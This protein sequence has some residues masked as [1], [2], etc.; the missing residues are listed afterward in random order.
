MLRELCSLAIGAGI[1]SAV[2]PQAYGQAA[3]INGE[4][5][6]VVT[7]S[8]RAAVG[9]AAVQIVNAATGFIEATRTE[10][11]GLYRFTLL[12]IGEYEITVKASGFADSRVTG[13][14]VNAGAAVTVNLMLQVAGTA[15]Q[16]DVDAEAQMTEPS[17]TAFSSILDHSA[18]S[19]LPLVSRNPYNFILFQPNVSGQANTEF[20][21][22][23]KVNANGFNGRINYELDGSNNTE[24][25]RSGVRLIPIS[26]SYVQEVQQVSNGFAP[27][28]GNTVGTVFNTI[29]RSGTN[30][31]HG[32]AMYIFRR[33]P[34]SARPKL[35]PAAAPT[36][37]INVDSYVA[38]AGG[39]IVRDKLFFFGSFEHVNRDLPAPVTVPTSII[40]QLRLPAS[41]ADSIP[42]RQ[43]VYFYMARADWMINPSNRL[44]LRYNHHANDSPYDY[45]SPP[46]GQ[47]LVSRT[48]NFVDRSHV[49]ALQ[50]ITTLSSRAVNELRVQVASRSQSN[51]RF[52][53]TGTG[54]AITVAGIAN[55]GG[56]IDVGFAY[57]ETAPEI[58]ENFSLVHGS[59]E[60]KAG[61]SSRWIRDEQVAATGALYV[62]P[63]VAAYLAAASGANLKGYSA[64][65]QTYGNPLIRYDSLFVGVFAQDSWKPRRDLTVVY[66]LRYDVYRPAE[67]NRNAPFPFSQTF[68][69]DKN[70]FAPRLGIAWSLG[71]QQKT[72]VRAY[73]GIFYD[74]FQTDQYRLALLQNGLPN[75]FRISA[76]P[77]QPLAPAFP[78]VLSILPTGFTLPPQDLMTVS[79][80]FAT[81]YSYN[82]SVSISREIARDLVA[83]ASYLYTK[84]TR[85]PVYRNINLVPSGAYLADGRPVF[86]TTARVYPG[87]NNILSAESAG[88]SNYNGMNLTIEKRWGRMGQL[89]AT[90]TWSHAIDDAPEQNNIDS[91]AFLSD[92]TNRRRD[93]ADSLTD[94]RHVFNMTGVFQ[95]EFH[96]GNGWAHRLLNGN[97]VALTVQAASGD[98]FDIGSN[99]VLN[100]DS[101]EPTAFQRPL[102]IGRNTLRGPAVFELNARYS[103]FFPISDRY[104][105]EFFAE[106]TNLTNTVNATAVNSIAQVDA[107]GQITVPASGAIIAA[108]DQRLIQLGL[109]VGF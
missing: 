62:F 94:K 80:D 36:P 64:F 17:G 90:Y 6:G 37:D 95:P 74:P 46:G 26:D 83:S 65:T 53:A 101:S 66:G 98:L 69:T 59:H 60:F 99:R 105:L 58:V 31:Y 86:S 70:N 34:F 91:T 93:R 25:D 89:F 49:G 42:F 50:L 85:L 3:A 100:L 102:F 103:R 87:F 19:N 78:D 22:P 20:G 27:E 15:T 97:M 2:M 12:P 77:I 5:T 54:P 73:N 47:N 7:D 52:A 107:A 39:R 88:N 45:S 4:I 16:I 35:L 68:R 79:P 23:R 30:D 75:F 55:F 44:L 96:I 104:K 28:F 109:R 63:T 84:G 51:N 48:Y 108:R 71:P 56:P 14:V 24:S 40:G 81:M 76:L 18:A 41:Y 61:L 57:T 43:S 11:S 33:T 29:T 72:V 10:S 82:A 92:S 67:A 1:L 9:N 38:D 8:S 21:V 106:T 32:D 13:T